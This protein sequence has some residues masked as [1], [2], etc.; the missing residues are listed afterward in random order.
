MD[1]EEGSAQEELPFN[2]EPRAP[3]PDKPDRTL[4]GGVSGEIPKP[5]IKPD[6]KPTASPALTQSKDFISIT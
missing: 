2:P 5:T 4:L 1:G 6:Q 3:V